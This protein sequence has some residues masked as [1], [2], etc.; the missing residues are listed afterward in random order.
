[1]E[2]SRA[3]EVRPT[4]NLQGSVMELVAAW[5]RIWVRLPAETAGGGAAS[6]ILSALKLLLSVAPSG[7]EAGGAGAGRAGGQSAVEHA[8]SSALLLADLCASGLPLDA[9]A[10]AAG[11]LADAYCT[12]RVSY[13]EVC[14]RLGDSAG[15]LLHDVW[16][17]RTAPKR[18]DLSDDHAASALRELCLSFYDVRAIAVETVA[19]VE[20]MNRSSEVPLYQQQ[21]LAL[22]CLQIYAPLGHAIGVG[23]LAGKL[24][25]M[26]FK[27]LFPKSYEETSRWL[28]SLSGEAEELLD[29]C[30]EQL[31]SAI[32]AN[33]TFH[34]LA[35]DILLR[36]RTKSL[37]STMKKLLAMDNPQRGGRKRAEV[38]DL[39]GI[40]AVVLP[41]DDGGRRPQ[42]AEADATA[43]CYVVQRVAHGLWAPI[44]E[45]TKDYIATP[46]PNGYQ[47]L[48]STL[49]VPAGDGGAEAQVL[50]LQVRT[51]QM[52][53]A[54]ERGNA[55]HAAYKGGLDAAQARKLK[56]WTEHLLA[57]RSRKAPVQLGT[58][59]SVTATWDCMESGAEELFRHLDQDGDG[60]ISPDEVEHLLAELGADSLDLEES[61]DGLHCLSDGVKSASE[62]ITFD[63]FMRFRSRVAVLHGLPHVDRDCAEELRQKAPEA[64]KLM[65]RPHIK[66]SRGAGSSAPEGLLPPPS[67]SASASNTMPTTA[68]PLLAHEVDAVLSSQEP[69]AIGIGHGGRFRVFS[70][71]ISSEL[72]ASGDDGDIEYT[73]KIPSSA[74]WGEDLDEDEMRR[75]EER[76]ED[77]ENV[78]ISSADLDSEWEA[79]VKPMQPPRP[80][81]RPSRQTP[82]RKP[83]GSSRYGLVPLGQCNLVE[84]QATYITSWQM[85]KEVVEGLVVPDAG[86]MIIGALASRGCDTIIDMDEV[87]GI[88]ARL[89]RIVL[90]DGTVAVYL[91]DL[92]STNGTTINGTRLR[93]ERPTKA[94]EGDV[95]SF[96]GIDFV[97]LGL[98]APPNEASPSSE[99]GTAT[100]MMPASAVELALKCGEDVMAAEQSLLTTSRPT[101]L[102]ESERSERSRNTGA[103]GREGVHD[104]TAAS[105]ELSSSGSSSSSSRAALLSEPG[106]L[107]KIV[108]A[109]VK[110]KKVGMARHLLAYHLR[111]CRGDDG[112]AWA[113]WAHLEEM[114]YKVVGGP[115]RA[116]VARIFYRAAVEALRRENT[117]E[118]QRLGCSPNLVIVL[119]SWGVQEFW[120]GQ[121][122]AAR[123]LLRSSVSESARH[124]DG[125]AGGGG[126]A[127]LHRW[128]K[129]ERRQGFLWQAKALISE[130]LSVDP[131]NPYLLLL[132]G[133][134]FEN[135]G[136]TMA[137]RETFEFALKHNPGFAAILHTWAR[138]EA[139]LKNIQLSR[140]L[141]RCLLRAE[142]TNYFALQAWGVAEAKCGEHARS[143]KIFQRGVSMF[144]TNIEMIQAWGRM[145]LSAGNVLEARELLSRA[146]RVEPRNLHSLVELAY[147]ERNFGDLD[148]AAAL[149]ERAN[150][151]DPES[152]A[153]R[154]EMGYLRVALGDR[155]GGLQLMAEAGEL[156]NCRQEQLGL[157]DYVPVRHNLHQ[158]ERKRWWKETTLAT[159]AAGGRPRENRHGVV[160][161]FIKAPMG[162]EQLRGEEEVEEEVDEDVE[163]ELEEKEGGGEGRGGGQ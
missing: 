57:S 13:N 141:F 58:P 11:I 24:E 56:S 135:S 47:S 38:N 49:V 9:E 89:E 68:L 44:P 83:V 115:K 148:E 154:Q 163:E 123:R 59:P 54:A 162:S 48:H 108:N 72:E 113:Q 99:T 160:R 67:A 41:R 146:L 53:Q 70:F 1:M 143:R 91:T 142:P 46:K 8:L 153:V 84:T 69:M 78:G 90:R 64:P 32:A 17:V 81:S 27:V 161:T 138:M 117:E 112:E 131:K 109:L 94:L 82:R 124:P 29:T 4:S 102:G 101:S 100:P 92:G 22:E 136:K 34:S 37:F 71:R 23:S 104:M 75:V 62:A 134:I 139:D 126:L 149:L 25:D 98:P 118:W 63:D 152:S 55:A 43:A 80:A 145:E 65:P 10:I 77:I 7:K 97:V 19:R 93:P 79:A 21:L 155:E 74:D 120:A 30:R 130:G 103:S 158:M 144:P 96:A 116:G 137:A 127:T 51:N 122:D 86:P 52:D 31:Q 20:Q 88:H 5:D 110:Q 45:R 50:E 15:Q 121:K 147:L 151:L 26:C 39:L 106:K 33:P 133:T 14:Q 76:S 85:G 111:L 2:P 107:R 157:R 119:R 18:V 16:R 159:L 125:I 60:I 132:K 12:E 114:A 36:G 3:L 66:P 35:G 140:E 40:R 28:Q 150:R 129:E 105:A 95:I 87:S 42:D 73:P 61:L 128:A 6:I 156:D